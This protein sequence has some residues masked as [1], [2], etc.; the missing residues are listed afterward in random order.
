MTPTIEA[1]GLRKRFGI[2]GRPDELWCQAHPGHREQLDLAPFTGRGAIVTR[3]FNLGHL[4]HAQPAGA[5]AVQDP[6]GGVEDRLPGQ[7]SPRRALAR[8]LLPGRFGDGHASNCT[9]R[10]TPFDRWNSV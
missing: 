5:V 4:A 2:G 6:E 7:R 8:G 9:R 10:R 1:A 3:D